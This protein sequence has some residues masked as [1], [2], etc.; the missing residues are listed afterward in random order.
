MDKALT[1]LLSR[2]VILRALLLVSSLVLALVLANMAAS[3][4]QV[5]R[6]SPGAAIPSPWNG[7][8]GSD[9]MGTRSQLLSLLGVALLAGASLSCLVFFL[10]R[11][12]KALL[13]WL[14]DV[15]RK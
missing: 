2:D 3:L 1:K 7:L 14:R 8:L 4:F 5:W 6:L 11:V 13:A 9:Q 15:T 10:E 12:V